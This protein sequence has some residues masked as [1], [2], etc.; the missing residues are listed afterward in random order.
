M[1]AYTRKK[2]DMKI[3]ACTIAKNEAKNIARCINSYKGFVDEIIVVDTGSTDDTVRIAEECGATVLYFDW[4]DDFSAAKNFAIEASTGDWIIFLDAD[5]YFCENCG[6]QV[7]RAIEN[8]ERKGTNAIFAREVNIDL[9]TGK[10]KSE[11]GIVRIFHADLRYHYPI[12][13]SIFSPQGLKI[14]SV[15]KAQF[16]YYHTGYSSDRFVDKL[17]RNLRLLQKEM[18]SG[19]N[20]DRAAGLHAYMCDCYSGLNRYAETRA[21]ARAFIEGKKKTNV[22]MLGL[23]AKPY[24]NSIY[25]LEKENG[26]LKELDE[27]ITMLETAFPRYPDAF[28]ARARYNFRRKLFAKAL[29]N[30]EQAVK[31]SAVYN[32]DDPDSVSAD[33][34]GITYARG[35]CRLAAGDAAG[36]LDLFADLA[37]HA[38]NNAAMLRMLSIV[39]PMGELHADAFAQDFFLSLDD[40]VKPYML[41]S[42]AM[43]YLSKPATFGYAYL[44]DKQRATDI[45]ATLSGFIQAGNGDYLG[46]S[47]FFYLNAV[48]AQ[49]EESAMRALLCAVLAQNADALEHAKSVAPLCQQAVLGVADAPV[50]S[51]D[52]PQLV[53]LAVETD[54]LCGGAL[55]AEIARTAVRKLGTL[56]ARTFAEELEKSFVYAAALAAVEYAPL[57]SETLFLRGYY[58]YRLGRMGEAEDLLR[59]AKAWG[60]QPEEVDATLELVAAHLRVYRADKQ[61]DMPAEQARIA[62]RLERGDFPVAQASLA[63]L[64]ELAEPDAQW[65]SMAAVTFYYMGQDERAALIVQAG[66]LRFP[67]NADL[68]YNAGDIYSRM[69]MGPRAKSYYEQALRQ[70]GDEELCEQIRAALVSAPA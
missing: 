56:F 29:L 9:S 35:L 4:C 50:G 54:R 38:K 67:K 23:E 60:Y 46:A 36:A 31:L 18:D 26:S 20:P 47:N 10:L 2:G 64:R 6:K 62:A 5:Q 34:D 27:W 43:C 24:V 57:T 33:L 22:R 39:K 49:N 19:P 70:C 11:V 51:T 40:A 55:S 14:M 7:R 32:G 59:L 30:Y 69:G 13:E 41:G 16:F 3:S 44:R 28:Y 17:E 48:G 21:E 66:L 42:M 65:Y 12:H 37:R 15:Q 61:P 58:T 68:L 63:A 52:I 25:S 1:K 53:S 45:D 8:A